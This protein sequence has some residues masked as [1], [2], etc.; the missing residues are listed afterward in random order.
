MSRDVL[1]FGQRMDSCLTTNPKQPGLPIR[2]L[3]QDV[4]PRGLEVQEDKTLSLDLY[5][6][7]KAL[8][9]LQSMHSR[10]FQSL[11]V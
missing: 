5:I 1:H 3:A 7:S 2:D 11:I 4:F 6:M 8:Y 10:A 9:K